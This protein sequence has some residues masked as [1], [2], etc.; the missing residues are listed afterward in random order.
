MLE[1]DPIQAYVV[2]D[3]MTNSQNKLAQ[4]RRRATI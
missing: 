2:T 3:D 4:I 1:P